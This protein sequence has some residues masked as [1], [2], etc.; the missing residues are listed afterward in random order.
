M[1]GLSKKAFQIEKNVQEYQLPVLKVDGGS[2][3]F[4]KE[5]L[6]PGMREQALITAAGIVKAYNMMAYDAVA[7][8]RLDLTGGID[9][10]LS[11]RDI[12]TFAWLSANLVDKITGKPFFSP[13]TITTVNKLRIGI[14]G[15]TA[16]GRDGS[17]PDQD[18]AAIIPWQE[19][20]PPL[21]KDLANRTDMIILLSNYDQQNNSRIANIFNEINLI[22]QAGNNYRNQEPNITDNTLI[23]Q[24]GKQGKYL[25]RLHISW[26]P[27]KTWGDNTRQ[28]KLSLK[29]RELDGINS[30]YRR[31]EARV[32]AAERNDNPALQSLDKSRERL[33]AE[34]ENLQNTLEQATARGEIA[35]T[36]TNRFI[37]METTLPDN[38]EVLKIVNET[39]ERA[40]AFNRKIATAPAT[41]IKQK[42][43]GWKACERCHLSRTR[44]WQATAHAGAYQTL[45]KRDQ[46][47]N[48]TCIPCHVTIEM[49]DRS[50][51]TAEQFREL[52]TLPEER[53]Q[54]GCELCH[55]SGIDHVVNPSVS[56]MT[57]RPKKTVCLGC[58]TPEHDDNFIYDLDIRRI[59]CSAS[60]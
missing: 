45:K 9:Y 4:E 6:L 36:Y 19:A 22:I 51:V 30:R 42:F 26:R 50:M 21:L 11:L 28:N 23:C 35:A 2:L 14:I 49:D 29:Q 47:F 20:L 48:S 60:H 1:G 37:A 33:K 3:L 5:K 24:T 12:S 10:L 38:E 58:H 7:V 54:V 32:P 15:L 56:P 18:R 57:V 55:G 39:K 46:H 41:N 13:Y 44:S 59:S 17:I 25:G 53:R 34:L 27:S 40:N 16:T 52:L 31:T 8:N 43:T